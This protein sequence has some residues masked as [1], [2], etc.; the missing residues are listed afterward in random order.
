MLR[1]LSLTGSST[2]LQTIKAADEDRVDDGE[3]SSNKTNLS[4]SN[5]SKRLI[6]A[7]YLT[8]QGTKKGGSNTK[9]GVKAIEGSDYPTSAVKKP[10]TTY[11]T[12][13]YKRLSFNALI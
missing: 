2:I 13:L 4:N 9:K 6:R 7:S 12:G 10:L 5:V 1:T 3:S 11:G 8:F